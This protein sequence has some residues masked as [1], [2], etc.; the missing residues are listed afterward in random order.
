MT[1]SQPW[2]TG[3][4]TPTGTP[5]APGTTDV[6]PAGHPYPAPPPQ[7][8]QQRTPPGAYPPPPVPPPPAPGKR[9]RW[10]YVVGGIVALLVVV[11]LVNGPAPAPV[12]PTAPVP[13]AA[14]VPA[15]PS[16]AEIDSAR[17]QLDDVNRQLAQRRAEL[18]NA[19][20]VPVAPA[21]VPAP[22]PAPAP[23]T[24]PL[25]T[26]SDG[27]YQVGVDMAAGRYKTTG[28]SGSSALD[29]CYV[30]RNKNDSGEFDAIIA[31]Q[32][33]QGPGSVTVGKGEFAEFSG[34]CRWTRQ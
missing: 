11:A 6:P 33:V 2:P 4:H 13:A 20:A 29:M 16:Q 19:P 10:P 1:S 23:A 32:I 30:S 21:P 8:P 15:G 17:Q 25:T 9:R 18:S 28:P 7:I 34:G 24:G 22:A 27:T 14:P 3:R 31:N 5:P 26:V 12:P